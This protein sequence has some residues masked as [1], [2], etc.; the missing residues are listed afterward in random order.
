MRRVLLAS[1]IVALGTAM[2]VGIAAQGPLSESLPF[3]LA[4]LT[5]VAR[6]G[7]TAS[8]VGP[9]YKVHF[10]PPVVT[11]AVPTRQVL[12]RFELLGV[13][14]GHGQEVALAP[15]VL[16]V[17]DQV[18]EYDRGGVVERYELRTDGVEQSFVFDEIPHGSGDLVVRGKLLSNVALLVDRRDGLQ[19]GRNGVAMARVGA[20]TGVDGAGRTQPGDLRRDGLEIEMV[21]PA[22]FVDSAAAPLVLDPLIGPAVE[23]TRQ[24]K[25]VDFDVV[26]H[27]AQDTYLITWTRDFFFDRDILGQRVRPDGTLVGLLLPIDITAALTQ[28]PRPASVRGAGAFI[29]GY[30]S[31]L[32]AIHAGTG[33]MSAPGAGVVA[34]MCGD[35]RP[36]GDVALAIDPSNGVR[37]WKLRVAPGGAGITALASV[38]LAQGIAT[39]RASAHG[40]RDGRYLVVWHV[41]GGAGSAV[42][43][44]V[45]DANLNVL[46]GAFEIAPPG[47]YARDAFVDGDGERWVV[48]YTT[49]PAADAFACRPIGW[50]TALGRV[51]IGP[52]LVVLTNPF[53]TVVDGADWAGGSYILSYRRGFGTSGRYNAFVG[54]IDPFSCLDCESEFQLDPT[55]SD[56]THLSVGFA[57]QHSG[58]LA[59]GTGGLAVWQKIVNPGSFIAATSSYLVRYRTRDG[60]IADLG[61][62]CGR[63]GKA[64]ATCAILGNPAFD[65]RAENVAPSAP[66]LLLIAAQALGGGGLPCGPCALVPNP[67]GG[68]VLGST[69]SPTGSLVIRTPLPAA[70]SLVGAS[71]VEQWLSLTPQPSCSQFSIDFSN[72]VRVT[73]E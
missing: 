42:F 56:T 8:G 66:A 58:S 16:R 46:Q 48:T 13:R 34:D 38:D 23:L 21:L 59:G 30:D 33:A 43:G 62:G 3:E 44:A 36:A 52:P 12:L 5:G 49:S 25:D 57:T 27:E 10:T 28:S 29:V 26:Y 2:A 7:D 40:G 4:S 54:S 20:V 6:E 55:A 68:F 63:G 69:S 61:G 72:A 22:A 24:F 50:N 47:S 70:P 51:V 19:Y 31:G 73:I 65:H 71:L 15:P 37:V 1:R 67:V 64:Y 14:R 35:A 11:V 9:G 41:G 17:T 39:P 53:H 32:R 60:G 45:V 18:V